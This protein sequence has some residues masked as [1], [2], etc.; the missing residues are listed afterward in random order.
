MSAIIDEERNSIIGSSDAP[1]IM[2]VSPWK[3][4]Y[5]LWEEKLGL[6][7]SNRMTSAME[8]GIQ[9]EEQARKNFEEQTGIYVIPQKV[10][11][12]DKKWM[13]ASLDGMDFDGKHIVEIKCP[14]NKDH[15]EAKE[16]KVPEKYIP[17]IQHQLAVTGLEMAFYFSFDG[18]EGVIVEVKKDEKYI[19]E[20]LQKEENFYSCMNTFTAPKMSQRDFTQMLE[21]DFELYEKRYLNLEMSIKKMEKEK[22]DLKN[23][24]LEMAEWKNVKGKHLAIQKVVRKGN[25]DYKAIPELQTMDLEKY[26]VAPST[27]WRITNEKS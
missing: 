2:E 9:L 12:P 6:R 18:N 15:S 14:N 7:K 4:P 22:E 5:A 21:P 19:L 16:G 17:Q 24:M 20:L 23:Q 8:R 3:T 11:H 25:I 27:F 1:V 26:R 10:Y 13:R